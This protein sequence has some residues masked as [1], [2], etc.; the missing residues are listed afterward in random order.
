MSTI[1]T[2]GSSATTSRLSAS[3]SPTDAA[4]STS[5]SQKAGQAVAQEGEVLGDH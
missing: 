1:A 4:T 2:S 3:P 5:L